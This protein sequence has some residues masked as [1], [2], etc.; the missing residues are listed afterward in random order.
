M[1]SLDE[2]D[3]KKHCAHNEADTLK[4]D[5]LRRWHG[6][7]AWYVVVQEAISVSN[8]SPVLYLC[9]SRHNED[10]ALSSS[11]YTQSSFG[12]K[13]KAWFFYRGYRGKETVVNEISGKETIVNEMS[14]DENAQ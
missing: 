12:P 11:Y 8:I 9:D 13:P 7:M 3:E 10:G 4:K 1:A 6:G 2:D 5:L 14:G